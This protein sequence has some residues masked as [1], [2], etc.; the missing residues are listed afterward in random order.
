MDTSS[1]DHGQRTSWFGI[2]RR[3]EMGKGTVGIMDTVPVSLLRGASQW[4]R[5]RRRLAA[6]V[7]LVKLLDDLLQPS[8]IG[9]TELDEI[10]QVQNQ[11][12]KFAA[13]GSGQKKSL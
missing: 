11:G 12:C 13:P 1:I 9:L 6:A 8:D 4:S 7:V 2:H 5:R 10:L 3:W